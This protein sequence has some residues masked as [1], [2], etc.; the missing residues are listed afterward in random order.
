MR[1]LPELPDLPRLRLPDLSRL[2]LAPP[3][4]RGVRMPSPR[5]P[6]VHLSRPRLDLEDPRDLTASLQFFFCL[7]MF[8]AL[9]AIFSGATGSGLAMLIAGAAVHVVRSSLAETAAQRRA[10]R[11]R[12]G[13]K[14]PVRLRSHRTAR[15][16]RQ[17]A[18]PPAA[19]AP[20]LRATA[21]PRRPRVAQ[22]GPSPARKQRV[23]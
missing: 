8:V 7:L 5:L 10:R 9:L 21:A 12:A 2:R 6:R 16:A 15:Q 4:L 22:P 11:E 14:R 23:I 1:H 13:H 17:A 18:P 3:R 20:E 19:P